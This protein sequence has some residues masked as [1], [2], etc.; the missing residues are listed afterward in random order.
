MPVC[1]T[2]KSFTS[3]E[4]ADAFV[5]DKNGKPATSKTVFYAVAKAAATGIFTDWDVVFPLTKGVKGAKYKKFKTEAEA[6]EFIQQWGDEETI[7][8][9][10]KQLG[11]G[12][13]R[14]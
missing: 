6:F 10:E 9:A 3:R 8:K 2:D 4:E 5:A 13:V 12:G 7:A 1:I 11:D 14:M